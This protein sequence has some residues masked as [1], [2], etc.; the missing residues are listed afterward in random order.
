[1]LC[2]SVN[3]GFVRRL[4]SIVLHWMTS[5]VHPQLPEI[6]CMIAALIPGRFTVSLGN[7]PSIRHGTATLHW[8]RC[9]PHLSYGF[10]LSSR[11]RIPTC[12][13]KH[14]S[15]ESYM[16][17]H[18]LTFLSKCIGSRPISVPYTEPV[19]ASGSGFPP[20]RRFSRIPCS[21]LGKNGGA[22]VGPLVLTSHHWASNRSDF[23][24]LRL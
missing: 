5:W 14:R 20:S 11:N 8:A 16:F 24:L 23:S 21:A 3:V 18:A 9:Q 10:F 19:A 12:I 13:Y 17:D 22:T 6:E 15:I 1:M 2:S 4:R 7:L